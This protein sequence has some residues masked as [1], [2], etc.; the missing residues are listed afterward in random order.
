M[1]SVIECV[2]VGLRASERF[3]RKDWSQ[4]LGLALTHGWMPQ[5]AAPWHNPKAQITNYSTTG[6]LHAKVVSPADALEIAKALRTVSPTHTLWPMAE[7]FAAFCA[8]GGFVFACDVT[9]RPEATQ[10]RPGT[11]TRLS[12]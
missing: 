4:L 3:D 12:P 2:R 8:G 11:T 6:W 10:R 9:D 7:Q 1:T 5:G